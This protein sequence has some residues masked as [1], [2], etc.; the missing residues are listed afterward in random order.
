MAVQEYNDA[1]SE[2]QVDALF[3][4]GGAAAGGMIQKLLTAVA[5]DDVPD[6]SSTNAFGSRGWLVPAP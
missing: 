4:A 2:Y 1:Q 5:S 6:V 3:M